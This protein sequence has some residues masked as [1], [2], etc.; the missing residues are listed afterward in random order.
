MPDKKLTDSEIVKALECCSAD[1]STK[2]CLTCPLQDMGFVGECIPEKSKNALD[3][4]NR[5]KAEIERFDQVI[6]QALT[7]TNEAKALIEKVE[8][9][10]KAEAY[11]EFAEKIKKHSYF[12]HKDQRKVVAE[13]IID[14]YLKEMGVDSQ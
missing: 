8:K 5:Q 3:L 14:H 7:K 12:D 10:N 2:Y 11:K 9:M 4:I 1:K 13:I 6:D